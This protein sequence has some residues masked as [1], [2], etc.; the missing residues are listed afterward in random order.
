MTP[1][2][3]RTL[4][5]L[6]QTGAMH[7]QPRTVDLLMEKGYIV[8]GDD[9]FNL[10]KKGLRIVE[11]RAGGG[12]QA[13]K[14]KDLRAH[15]KTKKPAKAKRDRATTAKEK[16]EHLSSLEK[17]IESAER[18]RGTALQRIL[19]PSGVA[20]AV[21]IAKA[22]GEPFTEQDVQSFRAAGWGVAAAG[23]VT[24]RPGTSGVSGVQ[25]SES[26][27]APFTN[28]ET[29]GPNGTARALV[30]L[31]QVDAAGVDD[32]AAN[33]YDVTPAPKRIRETTTNPAPLITKFSAAQLKQLRDAY[34][35]LKRV[36]PNSEDVEKLRRIFDKCTDAALIQLSKA[37]I[38]FV[39]YFALMT[40]GK[41][42]L[43]TNPDPAPAKLQKR[44]F[45]AMKASAKK[46]VALRVDELAE[47]IKAQVEDVAAAMRNL[48]AMGL[49]HEAGRDL[50]G[51]CW[52][53][54]A[55]SRGL[56]DNP[57][58]RAKAEKKARAWFGKDSLVTKAQEIDWTP[59]ESAVH[60]GQFIAIE[61]LSDKFD[62]VKRIY[63]HDVTKVRQMLLSPD[64]STIIVN[65]P[66]KITKRGIE[67]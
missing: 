5:E 61:Y 33:G 2:Q 23:T 65:P 37:K 1:A 26:D 17:H 63:R 14:K 13:V 8:V 45:D 55:P 18:K 67:G 64:G 7:S 49:A 59:P 31:G 20:N 24:A 58:P 15:F 30:L 42:G 52:L 56:F 60:I 10:T 44:V 9:G 16:K 4:A 46:N 22:S 34:S 62:G 12:L 27:W 21:K 28:P 11:G 53:P 47:R 39:S 25:F 50:F 48:A 40:A 54:G 43:T 38:N 3:K 36:D 29:L 19:G 35:G 66:F 51:P 41:R 6:H 57:N 32:L